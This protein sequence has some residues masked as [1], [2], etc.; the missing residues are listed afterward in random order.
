MRY[1]KKA[2][3]FQPAAAGTNVA[4]TPQCPSHLDAF[5]QLRVHPLL[6][7]GGGVR[8]GSCIQAHVKLLAALLQLLEAAAHHHQRVCCIGARAQRSPALAGALEETLGS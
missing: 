5:C 3:R 2:S 1:A 4:T 8:G 7:A 6:A